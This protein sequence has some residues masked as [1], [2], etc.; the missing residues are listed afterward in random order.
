MVGENSQEVA[1]DSE[2]DGSTGELEESEA[3]LAKA[4]ESTTERHGGVGMTAV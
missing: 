4:K 1:V 2:D 3:G